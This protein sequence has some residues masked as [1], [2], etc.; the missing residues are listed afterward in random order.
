[1]FAKPVLDSIDK[2]KVTSLFKNSKTQLNL[3]LT[4]KSILEITSLFLIFIFLFCILNVKPQQTA[5][6]FFFFIIISF[7]FYLLS[8]FY[9]SILGKIKKIKNILFTMGVK[10]LK[11]YRSLNS[12]TIVTMGLGMTM[13]FFLGNLSFNINKELNTSIP[14]SAPDYFFLGIQK[15]ELNLFSEQIRKIDYKAK[16]IVVPLISARIEAINDKDPRKF[17]DKKNRSFWFINGE[18]RISWAKVPPANNPVVEGKW[19]DEDK[20]NELKI[21]IDHRVAKDLR[22]KIGDSMTFNIYGNSVSGIIHNFRKVDYR[23]LNINFAVLF[24]PKYASKIPH[25]FMST[26]KFENEEAVKLSDLL[27]KLPTV[28]YIKLS[29]YIN[30]TKNFLNG[31]FTVSLLISGTVILIGLIV[32]SNA[33]S[34]IGNLKVY[35]NLVLRI[36]GFGRLNTLKLI[37]F[38]SFIL[39]IPIV[40]SSQI[41]SIIF[42]YFFVTNFFGIDWYFPLSVSLIITGLFLFVFFTTL[43]ISNRKYL[44]FNA[45]SLLR[46]E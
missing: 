35:Q 15:N 30:K 38:E 43:F 27:N 29:E 5:I 23:D 41:L 46:N 40:I 18:R 45:Y 8:K 19:W 17:T 20:R 32:I 44:N 11:A 3:S 39:F 2:I 16:Q 22:L 24:N 13:L 21:S 4:R 7:Y 14:K 33:L 6:F 36:L 25:E 9:I 34:V 26:V 1:M 37:I 10:N 31:L 28:T 12:I 42:S